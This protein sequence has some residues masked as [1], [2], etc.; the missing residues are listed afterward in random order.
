MGLLKK[1][2]YVQGATQQFQDLYALPYALPELMTLAN[3]FGAMVSIFEDKNADLNAMKALEDCV[4]GDSSVNDFNSRFTTLVYGVHLTEQSR[5]ALY[6]A[7]LDPRVVWVCNLRQDWNKAED[8]AQRLAIS[9]EFGCA[10]EANGGLSFNP[11]SKNV[12]RPQPIKHQIQFGSQ[13]PRNTTRMDIHISAVNT[14][15]TDFEQEKAA[16]RKI[17]WER[18]LCFSC[19]KVFDR[20]HQQGGVR[21]CPNVRAS[22]SDR[23]ALLKSAVN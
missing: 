13:I 19:L 17:C 7:A 8:L 12:S 3:F 23:L 21:S 10:L 9:S 20:A 6:L 16:I 22:P 2:A 4:Q 1:N 11:F 18:R 15:S 14:K 5:I